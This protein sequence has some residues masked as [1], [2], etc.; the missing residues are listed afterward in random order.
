MHGLSHSHIQDMTTAALLAGFVH[1][2]RSSVQ[3]ISRVSKNVTTVAIAT[4]LEDSVVVTK[5]LID[6]KFVQSCM[7]V[8]QLRCSCYIDKPPDGNHA[9]STV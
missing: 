8:H 4:L 1:V 6:T 3:L 9:M 7:Q 5:Q 2:H